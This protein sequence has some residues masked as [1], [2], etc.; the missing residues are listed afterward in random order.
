M[1]L[2]HGGLRR[3]NMV[4]TRAKVGIAVFVLLV[5]V[6]AALAIYFNW[7]KIKDLV[8]GATAA[9]GVAGVAGLLGK[10]PGFSSDVS[11]LDESGAGGEVGADAIEGVEGV[12]GVA[13][14]A[15]L[16]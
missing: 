7:G 12:E 2:S 11:K 1:C 6:G 4:S 3:A 10:I 9:A 14:E 8:L 15:A 5:L 13:P 16:A